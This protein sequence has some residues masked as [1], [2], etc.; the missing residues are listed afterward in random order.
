MRRA[1]DFRLLLR[2]LWLRVLWL[3]WL[4]ARD[5]LAVLSVRGVLHVRGVRDVLLELRNVCGVRYVGPMGR[6]HAV[7]ITPTLT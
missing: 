5:V 2:G 4:H 7:E 6:A 3:D 1:R